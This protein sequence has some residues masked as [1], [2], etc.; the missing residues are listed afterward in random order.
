MPLSSHA[1]GG[2]ASAPTIIGHAR[3]SFTGSLS[4]AGMMAAESAGLHAIARGACQPT[5]GSDRSLPPAPASASPLRTLTDGVRSCC[6]GASS[7]SNRARSGCPA[8]RRPRA[9]LPPDLN[10]KCIKCLSSSHRVT[11]CRLLPRSLRYRGFRHHTRDYK[12]LRVAAAGRVGASV[13][14]KPR[15]SQPQALQSPTVG[16]R[17]QAKP[18]LSRCRCT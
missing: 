9:C 1:P 14:G 4:G 13:T 7:W 12:R 2:R 10:G 16:R 6:R 15:R 5:C 11:T 3:T 17:A 18:W 8:D